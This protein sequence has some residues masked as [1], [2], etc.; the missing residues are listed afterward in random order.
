METGKAEGKDGGFEERKRTSRRRLGHDWPH[1]KARVEIRG[2]SVERALDHCP[3][4]QRSDLQKR[5]VPVRDEEGAG[6]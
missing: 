3:P 6:S 5:G 4:R 2:R 1:V